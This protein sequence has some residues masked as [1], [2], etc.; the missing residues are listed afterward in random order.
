MSIIGTV[1]GGIGLA[2]MIVRIVGLIVLSA[3]F[4]DTSVPEGTKTINQ[5]GGGATILVQSLSMK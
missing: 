5:L 2:I 3:T 1:V 4:G